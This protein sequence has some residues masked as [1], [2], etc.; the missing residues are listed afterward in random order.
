MMKTA[1][2]IMRFSV[3]SLALLAFVAMAASVFAAGTPAG[4]VI[5]NFAIGNYKDANG[6]SL[7][8]VTSNTVTTTVAQVA[9]VD[10]TPGSG[11][12]NGGPG[13]TVAYPVTITNNGN[14]SDNLTITLDT[15]GLPVG[16][17]GAV[18]YDA[19]GDGVLQQSEID[20]GAVT[21]TGTLAADATFK[22]IVSVTPS[23]GAV[24]GDA[25]AVTLTA[26]ATFDTNVSDSGTFTTTTA[27]V[28]ISPIKSV[29]HV[30]PQSGD[31]VT[32]SIVGGN[33]GDDTAFNVVKRDTIPANTTYIANSV[34]LN[35]ASQTDAA[36]GDK[37][38]VSGG[39]VT[40]VKGDVAPGVTGTITFQVRVNA[41][42]P[43]GTSVSNVVVVDYESPEGNAQP[44]TST[45]TST[46]IVSAS[47]GV[48]VTPDSIHTDQQTG[49]TNLHP[50]TV[51][52]TGNSND[53][54]ELVSWGKHWVWEIWRDLDGNEIIDDGDYQITDTD[55]DGAP[56]TGEIVPGGANG[57]V[58]RTTLPAGSPDG[59]LGLHIVTATSS[60][61]PTISDTSK[62][63]TAVHAPVLT[64]AKSVA[65]AGDQLRGTVL[66]YTTTYTNSGSGHATAVALVDQIPANTTYVPGSI[67][68]DGV[69]VTDADDGDFAKFETGSVVVSFPTLGALTSGTFSFQVTIN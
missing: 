4:T 52:N 58:A 20:A 26:T 16:W 55:G 8:Q 24:N 33:S 60:V 61:D 25:G 29:S 56:D 28:V 23:A 14:G 22:V 37:T 49:D 57:F 2:I 38:T 48:S 40:I 44:T 45:N 62:K 5:S 66:T 39:V 36:D 64:L 11:A 30:S 18:Y 65:P 19:N 32:Y 12:Q 3:L 69:A 53:T 27:A 31:V 51:T 13:Q 17:T 7:P 68:V 35:G 42:V 34:T 46:F 43:A 54:F 67:K 21:Q 59:Q 63:T 9:G 50:F 6:N 47:A 41:G 1:T 10:V 15:S